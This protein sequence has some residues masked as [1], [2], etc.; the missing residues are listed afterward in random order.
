[1]STSE[2]GV[3]CFIQRASILTLRSILLRHCN[4]F[5]T[6]QLTVI[7]EQTILPAIQEAAEKDKSHVVTITSESPLISNIDFLVDSLPLP[8]DPDDVELLQF[9]AQ[10]NTLKRAW[11]PAELMLEASFTDLRYGGDGD[12]RKAY[13]LSK[14]SLSEAS[15]TT[16]QPFPDSW[17]ATT[18]SLAL[19]LLTDLTTEFVILRGVEG[20]ERIWPLISQQFRLWYLGQELNGSSRSYY[21]WSPCEALVRI[22]CKE[23]QRLSTRLSNDYDFATLPETEKTVWSSIL[24]NWFSDLL[25]QSI[26]EEENLRVELLHVGMNT[27]STKSPEP[28]SPIYVVSKKQNITTPYGNGRIERLQ[29]SSYRSFKVDV[30]VIALDF[31]ATLYRPKLSDSSEMANLDIGTKVANAGLDQGN[32]QNGKSF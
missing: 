24:L 22:S 25:A 29:T 14:K 2:S 8:P 13:T 5:S 27:H 31:G 17:L 3:G 7:L 21:H 26:E 1:M 6:S 28:T 9:E 4:L 20:R 32:I 16:E 10:H 23:M 11:G 18:A 30:D 15:A 12:L 19:G